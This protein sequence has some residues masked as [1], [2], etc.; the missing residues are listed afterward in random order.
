MEIYNSLDQIP[1]TG[2]ARVTVGSFDGVHRGHLR[3][4]EA[5][6]SEPG[7]PITIVTFTPHPQTVLSPGASPPPLLTSDEERVRLFKELGV[8]RLVVI[9]FDLQFATLEP[10]E[11]VRDI[12]LKRVGLGTL[13]VGPNHRFGRARKGDVNLLKELSEKWGFQLKVVEPV[14]DE[15]GVIS[16]TRIRKAL[17]NGEIKEALNLLTRP[18]QVEGRVVRG[19]GRGKELGFPTANLSLIHSHKLV[20]PQGIYATITEWDGQEFPSVT[21][22]GPRPT[23]GD[24]FSTLETF[25]HNFNGELYGEHLVIKFIDRL[26]DIVHFATIKELIE[27]MHRDLSDSL[28]RLDG[29]KAE[30]VKR[31]PTIKVKGFP[32]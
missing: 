3:I 31:D 15:K 5:L 11:F 2:K 1:P 9:P 29:W 25:I 26:R 12:L 27:Q 10:E 23:F 32:V 19:E 16:S 14:L 4:L 28:Q 17:L 18:Y 20:P 22:I 8:E 24:N 21:H 13:V 30:V 6:R 7:G